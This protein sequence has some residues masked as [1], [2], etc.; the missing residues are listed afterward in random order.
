MYSLTIV[1]NGDLSLD[2]PTPHLPFPP[3]WLIRK[4]K[5]LN[6]LIIEKI[7]LYFYVFEKYYLLKSFTY[8]VYAVGYLLVLHTFATLSRLIN[9]TLVFLSLPLLVSVIQILC[10]VNRSPDFWPKVGPRV[11]PVRSPKGRSY[12]DS[13]IGLIKYLRFHDGFVV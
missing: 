4:R 1:T 10:C 12:L 2:L 5:T 11:V 8:C 6:M 3:K 9:K 13:T 7:F